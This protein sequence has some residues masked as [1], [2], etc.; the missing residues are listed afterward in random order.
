MY[1]AIRTMDD[2]ATGTSTP[3]TSRDTAEPVKADTRLRAYYWLPVVFPMVVGAALLTWQ[4]AQPQALRG[5]VG[6]DEGAYFGAAIRMAHGQMPYLDYAFVHPPGIAVLLMPVALMGRLI[7]DDLAFACARIITAAVAITNI[8]LVSRIVRRHGAVATV[9]GGL[10]LAAFPLAVAATHT[11][12]LDP[13]LLLFTL[14]GTFLLF[15]ACGDVA[16]ARHVSV[17]GALF[18][19]AALVKLWALL[20]LIAASVVV[21]W[22]ARSA[23]RLLSLLAGSIV[24]FALG[25]AVFV[26]L[27]PARFAH[28]VVS[29]QLGRVGT[30]TWALSVRERLSL[31]LGVEDSP[32]APGVRRATWGAVGLVCVVVALMVLGRRFVRAVDWF[33]VLATV[34]MTVGVLSS[35]TFY[36]YY[37]YYP[38]ALGALLLGTCI[39]LTRSLIVGHHGGPR[40]RATHWFDIGAL[41]L[42]V[43]VLV[44]VIPHDTAYIHTYLASAFDESTLV[45]S[46]IPAGSCAI[47]DTPGVLIAADRYS[48]GPRSCPRLVDPYALFLTENEGRETSTVAPFSSSFVALWSDWF[49]RAEFVVLA[50]P[51]SNFVPWT[52]QLASEF[53]ATYELVARAERTFIYRRRN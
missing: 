9:A 48:T 5:V 16:D 47:S 36:R 45:R 15:D 20:P 28:D 14:L 11:V 27:A 21:V 46:T 35:A 52:P 26:M 25:A 22:S 34:A 17:A 42:V 31:L 33:A 8:G 49:T 43:T 24:A 12:L 6:Y 30:G 4:L 37:A 19:V 29:S 3:E 38:I 13:Y 40:I 39:G 44:L 10:L 32:T 7:G 50:G 51:H 41:G 2:M 18:G 1:R 23:R 53:D